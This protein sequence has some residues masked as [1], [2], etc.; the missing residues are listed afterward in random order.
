MAAEQLMTSESPTSFL[1][2]GFTFWL[3]TH[4]GSNA[5]GVLISINGELP[6]NFPCVE[7][8]IDFHCIYVMLPST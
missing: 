5:D 7:Q 2:Y 1:P 4:P 8:A 6:F 3:S